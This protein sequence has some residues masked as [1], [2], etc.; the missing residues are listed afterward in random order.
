MTG[1]EIFGILLIIIGIVGM[2]VMI[3]GKRPSY[4]KPTAKGHEKQDKNSKG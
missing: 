3:R 1:L 2:T 4:G